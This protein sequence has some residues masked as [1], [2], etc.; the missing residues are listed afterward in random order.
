MVK[1]MLKTSVGIAFYHTGLLRWTAPN[2]PIL[3]PFFVAIVTIFLINIS[4]FGF[5]SQFIY[6]YLTLIRINR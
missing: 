4:F 5:L 2:V 1:I 3:I 6:R